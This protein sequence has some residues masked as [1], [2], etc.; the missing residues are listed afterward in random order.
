MKKIL[1]ILGSI[2]VFL[3]LAIATVP[4]FVNVDQY[5]SELV[6]RAEQSL[7]GK[8]EIGKLSLSLWGQIRVDIAGVKLTDGEGRPV[9]EVQSAFFKMPF[10]S[11]LS[12]SPKLVLSMQEPMLTMVKD[13]K[14]HMNALSLFKS[15]ATGAQTSGAAEAK[16]V[17]PPM[18]AKKSP[19][20]MNLPG[21]VSRASLGV[22]LKN[23]HVGYRDEATGM[24]TEV[25]DLDVKLQDISLSHKMSL[26]IAASLD[27]EL[28]G[29]NGAQGLS[30]KG[31]AKITGTANPT[32]SAGRFDHMDLVVRVD[33]DQLDILMPGLFHKKA[34]IDAHADAAIALSSLDATIRRLDVKFFNAT[35]ESSGKITHLGE[36][37]QPSVAYQLKTNAID[38]R[39][40]NE[41]IPLLSEYQLGGSATLS[42]E[43]QGLADRLDYKVQ[44]K[45]LGL[46]AKAAHLKAEP[47]IDAELTIVPDKANLSA[48][49]KAPGS[50]LSV[51]GDVISFTHPLIR[52]DVSS[53]GIDLDQLIE[54]PAATAPKNA[55]ATVAA[56]AGGSEATRAPVDY[57]A[58]V[59]P[60]RE[61]KALALASAHVN[62]SIHSVKYQGVV[63]S[64]LTAKTSL[65]S[66]I[67]AINSLQFKIF[68][69]QIKAG[70]SIDLKPKMPDYRLNLEVSG[71]DLQQA[72]ASQMKLFSNTI[73]G[74]A[75]FDME[76]TGK[77][78]NPQAA[79]QNLNVKGKFKVT[80]ATFTSI[81]IA[82]MVVDAVNGAIAKA[83]EKMPLLKGKS[84]PEKLPSGGSRY[85]SIAS[86]F[87]I[88]N[89]SF[90]SPDFTAKASPSRGV[91]FR[92]ATTVGIIDHSLQANWEMIDTY[93]LTHARDISIDVLGGHVDHV[94]AQG[95]GPVQ[96]PVVVSGTL[97][98]P[99]FDYGPTTEYLAKV[100]IGNAAGALRKGAENKI[101]N[102]APPALQNALKGLF[103]Q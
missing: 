20:T 64:D 67:G 10:S 30:V 21:I 29:E 19:E 25:K 22:E 35:A 88:R 37:E 72:V 28:K 18:P 33:L 69:G 56:P 89:G 66:L 6:T 3:I 76:G 39:P 27:T 70:A 9:L 95:S 43:A 13:K 8:L 54:A 26:E 103:G 75:N 101:L 58:L 17:A 38:L 31:P 23:A 92:G 4:F 100:A 80:D 34:G 32:V 79:E 83:A 81:D 7:S 5:R 55:S 96:F 62:A 49:M 36:G 53:T 61:N 48:T 65:Q 46:T 78:L 47:K 86:S 42:L 52:F 60:M 97:L 16:V 85:D 98:A 73:I 14:G 44:V 40:W 51:I 94:L 74:K 68:G 90:S 24:S 84:L 99:K 1:V 15:S 57:D 12:G 2:L 82:K 63:L 102:Q 41:L 59:A 91:D 87:L 93:N 50:E 45:I 77:S 71:L 11:L